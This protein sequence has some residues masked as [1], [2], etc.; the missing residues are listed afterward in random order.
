LCGLP[1]IWIE[2]RFVFAR[3]DPR[4]LSYAGPLRLGLG[5]GLGGG[6]KSVVLPAAGARASSDVMSDCWLARVDLGGLDEH[7]PC[8]DPTAAIGAISLRDD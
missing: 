2:H 8:R 7:P 1:E 4:S 6:G 3:S 5:L